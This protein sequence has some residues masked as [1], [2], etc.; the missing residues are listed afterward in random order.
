MRRLELYCQKAKELPEPR[1]EASTDP[2]LVSQKEHSSAET[3]ISDFQPPNSETINLCFLNHSVCTMLA[4]PQE[5]NMCT[6]SAFYCLPFF[7]SLS[8][9]LSL[10]VSLSS[11]FFLFFLSLSLS[12]SLSLF[13]TPV[14]AIGFGLIALATA[15]LVSQSYPNPS[16][17]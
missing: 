3:L 1:R 9:S 6:K 4:L 14:I 12:P 5:S 2:S 15:R 11:F 10:T 16:Q 7:S 17:A 8:L 13:F